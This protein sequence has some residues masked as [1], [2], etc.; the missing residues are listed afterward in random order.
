MDGRVD[1]Y[2]QA[3]TISI[4]GVKLHGVHVL[5]MAASPSSSSSP[6]SS[7]V[8]LPRPG[9]SILKKPPPPQQPFF[10]LSRLS[11]LIPTPLPSPSSSASVSTPTGTPNT[12]PN[13]NPEGA[14]DETLKRAH[15]YLPHLATVYPF[16]ASNPPCSPN[17][18]EEKKLIDT[19]EAERRKRIV[20]GNS[21]GPGSP[22]SEE[23]WSPEKIELFY[24]ECCEGREE[25]PHPG[26]TAA[27][28]VCILVI[29]LA[30]FLTLRN[31]PI[32]AR[33]GRQRQVA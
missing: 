13:T 4:L 22:E 33:I 3:F 30:L 26:I 32:Q 18:R 28:K 17:Q 16:T 21:F 9:K 27:L 15:F 12:S 19:R 6:S 11:R 20:R 10:S 31:D 2:G 8:T 23:W 14:A 24:R 1:G 7:A 29:I 5:S 25:K